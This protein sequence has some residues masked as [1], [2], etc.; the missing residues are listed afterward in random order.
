MFT[1]LA[2]FLLYA[3]SFNGSEPLLDLGIIAYSPV[4]LSSEIN[5][6][7]LFTSNLLS[8]SYY[9]NNMLIKRMPCR[10]W[11][12][13]YSITNVLNVCYLKCLLRKLNNLSFCNI[14]QYIRLETYT[15]Y[16]YSSFI[17]IF[18][19][20]SNCKAS[21]SYLNYLLKIVWFGFKAI[22]MYFPTYVI[23]NKKLIYLFEWF[24]VILSKTNFSFGN[25]IKLAKIN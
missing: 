24:L 25:L 15:L 13:S 14:V 1:W 20:A 23:I 17:Q 4:F 21:M 7:W 19:Y 3:L 2:L 5:Y 9:V 8:N 11:N 10:R 16:C 12:S 22:Y 18:S 6:F